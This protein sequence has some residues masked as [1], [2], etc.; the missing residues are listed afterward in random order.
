M[1]PSF[2]TEHTGGNEE[3]TLNHKLPYY[4]GVQCASTK[5]VGLFS[6]RFVDIPYDGVHF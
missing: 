3:R 4:T 1:R 2:V 6:G 5:R